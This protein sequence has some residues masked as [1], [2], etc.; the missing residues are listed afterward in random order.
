MKLRHYIKGSR[1]GKEANRLEREAMTDPF[2]AE[3]LEGY[4]KMPDAHVE[5]IDVMRKRISTHTRKRHKTI[6]TWSVAASIIVVFSLGGYFLLHNTKYSNPVQIAQGISEDIQI[7]QN[8]EVEPEKAIA[9]NQ[10][11]QQSPPPPAPSTMDKETIPELQV[12]SEEIAVP[13]PSVAEVYAI[14]EDHSIVEEEAEIHVAAQ[15]KTLSGQSQ[16]MAKEKLTREKAYTAEEA[17]ESHAQSRAA[18]DSIVISHPVIGDE[19]YLDYIKKNKAKPMDEE[20]KEVKGR[21]VVSFLVNDKGRPYDLK[22]I[23]SICPSLDK[24]AIRLIEKG[25]DWTKG[26]QPVSIPIRFD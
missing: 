11:E 22:I 4:D 3:A 25:P 7:E 21:V 13:P 5:R 23:R 19:A 24:E 9:L 20:C 18:D 6:Y 12:L 2:L 26:N 14:T 15:A 16:A 8:S 10:R 17:Q 1:K